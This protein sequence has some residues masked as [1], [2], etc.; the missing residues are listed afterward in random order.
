MSPGLRFHTS[1]VR[2]IA[3]SLL[4][5]VLGLTIFTVAV[6]R[7]LERDTRELVFAQQY[8]TVSLVAER[9]DRTLREQVAILEAMA[10]QLVAGEQLRPLAEIENHLVSRIR[11]LR[12][13]NGGLLLLDLEAR[14]LVDPLAKPGRRGRSY[15]NEQHYQRLFAAGR[16]QIGPPIVDG[17]R[18]KPLLPISVPIFAVSGQPLGVLSGLLDLA[19]TNFLDAEARHPYGET[20]DYLI[21]DAD[22]GLFVAAANKER[23]LQPSP[24]PGVNP[25]HDRYMAGFE[26]S[27]IG[28]SSRGI[29][30]VSSAQRV[31]LTDWF[32]VARLPT[33]EAFAPLRNLQKLIILAALL[34]LLPIGGLLIWFVKRQLDP[35]V[36]YADQLDD[37]TAG[38]EP[39][40]LLPVSR[41][42]ELGR[43]LASFNHLLGS[44]R[45]AEEKFR[46][47]AEASPDLIFR[48]DD[49]GR[50]FYASPAAQAVMR[51]TPEAMVGVH[52]RH[53]VEEGSASQAYQV[54]KAAL[55]G[56]QVRLWE[57]TMRRGDQTTFV[58]E[59]S[60]GPIL[61]GERII[62]IQG[63]V[64]D[65]SARRQAA[66]ALARQLLFQKMVAT[67]SGAFINASGA[68]IDVAIE[69]ALAESG[70]FFNLDRASLFL[71]AADGRTMSNTHEWCAAGITPQQERIQEVPSDAYP[72]LTERLRRESFVHLPDTTELPPEAAAEQREFAA[73][74]IKSLL[75][76]PLRHAGEQLG[77]IGYDAIRRPRSWSEEEINL[78]KVV[79]EIIASA[80]VRRRMEEELQRRNAELARSNAELT[81]F[82]HIASHDLQEPLRKVVGFG[83]RLAEKCGDR[84]DERGADY[85]ARMQGAAQRMEGL[86]NDL[87]Q[88]ARVTTKGEEFQPVELGEVLREVLESLEY[89]LQESGAVIEVGEL[90]TVLGDRRQLHSLFQNLLSNALKYRRPEVTPEIRVAVADADKAPQPAANGVSITVSDNGIGFEQQYVE[91]I[92]RPFQRLHGRSSEYKG[93][94]IGLAICQKIVQ[95]HGGELT[96]TATPGTGA[97]FTVNLPRPRT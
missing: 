36:D 78:L 84:L 91:R 7:M 83:D 22:S 3:V 5:I 21:I 23:V 1:A 42:D 92:F 39:V 56:E 75:G 97:T 48:I 58:A 34:A 87:L 43:L 69:Q 17:R 94:G 26:G 93:S 70:A 59:V 29:E 19:A 10:D 24:L 35:L 90:P 64:R 41:D 86:I 71:L 49:D 47:I 81:D 46:G 72:W 15:L 57:M 82:A 14:V 2:I 67:I 89:S 11:L 8:S 60:A 65:V 53:F 25:M 73:R 44:V 40:A 85:L 13:F 6:L 31:P 33:A 80:L 28:V 96:A 63:V 76:L 37:M 77:F 38:R 74:Q 45:A 16:P 55:G 20:G 4:A 79:A 18:E 61:D 66:A 51:Y 27:G 54:F 88:Y 52:F 30:M 95:R 32:V 12:K 9:I 68:E 50:L 62:G